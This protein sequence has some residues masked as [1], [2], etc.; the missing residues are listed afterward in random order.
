[1][2]TVYRVFINRKTLNYGGSEII[3]D[4]EAGRT[5]YPATITE[6]EARQLYR[7]GVFSY[8]ESAEEVNR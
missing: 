1:M 5:S 2:Y 4:G 6:E 3:V 7:C 8:P